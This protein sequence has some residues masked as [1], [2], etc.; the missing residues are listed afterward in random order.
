MKEFTPYDSAHVLQ[1]YIDQYGQPDLTLFTPEIGESLRAF[2]FLKPGLVIIAHNRALTVEQKW[3]F[4]P[5]TAEAFINSW[6]AS[7]SELEP[8]PERFVQP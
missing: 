4:Q 1:Q 3:Y 2:V 6:G 5:V 7:L 8:A